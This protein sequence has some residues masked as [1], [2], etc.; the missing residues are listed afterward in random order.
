[1]DRET[2]CV[3]QKELSALLQICITWTLLPTEDSATII[4][5]LA[6]YIAEAY[7][8]QP[9]HPAQPHYNTTCFTRTRVMEQL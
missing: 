1:M 8:R 6:S 5:T 7:I 3:A 4:M 9:I 2:V